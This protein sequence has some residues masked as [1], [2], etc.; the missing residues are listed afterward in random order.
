MAV[1]SNIGDS[2]GHIR[3]AVNALEVG[4]CEIRRCSRLYESEPMYVEDQ[5]RFVNGVIEVSSG[6]NLCLVELTR[7]VTVLDTGR[8]RQRFERKSLLTTQLSTLLDPLSL[9]RLLK[10]IE[11]QIGRTKTFRNGPRV[12][13]LDL[14]FYG[15]EMMRIGETGDAEDEDG[16]GWLECPHPR[17]EEREF[18]LRPLAE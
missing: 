7:P 2:V 5:E 13:D 8:S 11:R 4:G 6:S 3:R 17:I 1:G 16:V 12:V 18:V 14:I 9:L 15:S 10:R